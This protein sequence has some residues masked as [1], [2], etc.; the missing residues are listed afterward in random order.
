MSAARQR[1]FTLIEVVVAFAIFTLAMGAL[2]EAFGGALRRGAQSRD[3]EES[4]LA[5]QSV[6]ASLRASPPPWKPDDSG[7]LDDWLWRTEIAPYDA[8]T[9][10]QRTSWR[11][12]EVTV[13][14]QRAAGGGGD[15]VL[16]SIELA[17]V[18]P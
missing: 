12:F 2:Y 16:K 13:H 9:S 11:A 1:G 6:L 10:Q 18:T 4:V 3:R 5:A 14:L 17:R 15:V 8:R 7:R